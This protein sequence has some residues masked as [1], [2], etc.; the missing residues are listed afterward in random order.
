M[1]R[2]QL[3]LG[4]P[5][6][7]QPSPR[8]DFSSLNNNR[9]AGGQKTAEAIRNGGRKITSNDD[10]IRIR[11]L[12]DGRSYSKNI[13]I[14]DGKKSAPVGNESAFIAQYNQQKKAGSFLQGQAS[15]SSAL[16]A[17]AVYVE[18]LPPLDVQS[19]KSPAPQL[20][21]HGRRESK[22]RL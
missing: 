6:R 2:D 8:H 11:I 9:S 4:Q 21:L 7:N 12:K 22:K 13:R 14:H 10:Q 18:R 19:Q 17:G 20:Y 15:N 1:P 16:N 3:F 5:G